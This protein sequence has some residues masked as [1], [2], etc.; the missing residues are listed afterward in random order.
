M[1]QLRAQSALGLGCPLD[2]IWSH[3]FWLYSYY[4]LRIH[5]H[6]RI[7]SWKSDEIRKRIHDYESIAN[8][9]TILT[10]N[11]SSGSTG[12]PK[13]MMYGNKIMRDRLEYQDNVGYVE[14]LGRLEATRLLCELRHFCIGLTSN[15]NGYALM[16]FFLHITN[17]PSSITILFVDIDRP[18][19]WC[20][21]LARALQ[22]FK[23]N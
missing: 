4:S 8:K 6:T 14:A 7:N 21:I 16:Y 9:Q 22:W 18:K 23:L 5:K 11:F 19:S 3:H 17:S 1:I 15:F 2:R 12:P 10:Y 20:R 13:T